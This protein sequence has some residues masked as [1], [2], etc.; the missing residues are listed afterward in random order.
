LEEAAVV[1]VVLDAVADLVSLVVAFAVPPAE[2]VL[3]APPQAVVVVKDTAISTTVA[4][5]GFLIVV[6][7]LSDPEMAGRASCCP[8]T[9]SHRRRPMGHTE[10]AVTNREHRAA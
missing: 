10:Q 5:T 9:I 3:L 7:R 1:G 6:R 4:R 8:E 2:S